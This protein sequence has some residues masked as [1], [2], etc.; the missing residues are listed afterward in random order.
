MDEEKQGPSRQDLEEKDHD[1]YGRE[2]TWSR[3]ANRDA[4]EL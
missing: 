2:T 4:Y 3:E 1:T